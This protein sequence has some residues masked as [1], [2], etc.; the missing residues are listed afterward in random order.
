MFIVCC[1]TLITANYKQQTKSSFMKKCIILYIITLF[2]FSSVNA[3]VVLP[4]KNPG[5]TI[6]QR[7][8]DLLQRMTIE[9]KFWQMFMIPGGLDNARPG[10]YD[11]G[12]FGFQVSA[13]S[14]NDN[15]A[16]QILHYNTKETAA[17]L[18]KKINSIQKY[19]VDSSR[20]GIPVIVFDEALHGLVREGATSFPQAIALAATWDTTLMNEVGNAIATQARIR[21]IRQI[22]SPVINIAADVRWGRTEETYGEDPF[23]TSAM[24]IAYISAFEKM[25]I[26][27]TPK[28]FIANVGDGGR[29]SYPIHF[30]ERLLDE[31]YFPPFE[32]VIKKA[33]A[34]SVMT[35]YN[36]LD[37]VSCSMN[38]WLLNEKLKKEWG[39]TGF[40]ISD[41]SAVGGANVLHYT[42]KDYPDAGTKAI[43]NG[44]DVIFQTDYDHYKLFI[45]PFL[46][47]TIDIKKIDDAV[48][49]IL[50]VKF[51]LGLFEDPYVKETII[52]TDEQKREYK[53]LTKKA[54]IESIVLLRNDNH[55]L[56]F[57]KK[58]KSIAVIGTDAIEARLGGYSGPGNDKQNILDGI[59]KRAGTNMQVMYSPGCGRKTEEWKVITT[60]YLSSNSE[61]KQHGLKATYF[62]NVNL[63]GDAVLTRIDPAIDFNW[64]LFPP[65]DGVNLDFYSVRWEG[66][67][68]G[69]QTGDCKI[70]L[71]GNDGFRLYLDDQ[72]VIDNWQK[73]TYSTRLVN[74]HFEKNKTYRI[75]VEFF[76]PNGNAHIR[77]VWNAGIIDDWK[78]KIKEAVAIVSK[79]SV[80]VIVTG[81]QEGEFQDRAFLSLP[82][83]QEELIKEIAATGKPVVIVLTGGSAVTM[84]AWLEK[85]KAVLNVW[86]PGE[87]GGNALA[88]ILFGDADPSGR[89]P[90]TYPISEAQLPLVYNHKPTGRGDD[91]NNLSGLP[92]FP[93]GFGLSYTHFEYSD[94]RFDKD[95][96]DTN[97]STTIRFN[98]KNAGDRAGDEVAQLYI[99]DLL[100]SVA[101]PVMELKG[102][103]RV[104]LL[105]GEVKE[106]SFVITP[107]LLSM[108]NADL[109]KLVE[110][111]DFRIMIGAS[112]RDIRLKGT[113]K[114]KR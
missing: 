26:V 54:A 17:S 45:P 7:V 29:D 113:L 52:E 47:S 14:A 15:A 61:K 77:L 91:Y 32:E 97:E 88:E 106:V 16:Q 25:N 96:I 67:L 72:L 78:D 59:K 64:T 60:D 75:R 90:I 114:V 70:G 99:R 80:A 84:N 105:P 110:P 13:A 92:L 3:Q 31:I 51:E 74:Y 34:R 63:Q 18:A 98:V 69:P 41:A 22:L 9:E 76:E 10:Q 95:K 73:Q 109:K 57:D 33:G 24:G 66:L 56:P 112:S 93:F 49:R 28:H 44:L 12:I 1:L 19:F 53:R 50:R 2:S 103:S 100:S 58:I 30:N 20:L 46:D 82:G 108:L 65:S 102:F 43:N 81:I 38:N 36:S 40:V 83:H 11:H 48:K 111:G 21:G 42:A 101:R 71:D 4:Y 55:I 62:N 86:Y 27:T 94:L 39:F 107:A 6:E 89:L 104:H 8:N 85:V 23:L 68:T 87:E 5:L 79:A 35:A 37:G